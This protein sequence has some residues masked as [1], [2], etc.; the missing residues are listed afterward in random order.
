MDRVAKWLDINKLLLNVK[1]TKLLVVGNGQRLADF[2]DVVIKLHGKLVDRVDKI[3]YLGVKLDEK[4]SWTPHLHDLFK[5]LGHKLALFNRIAGSLNPEAMSM[6][7]KSYVLPIF[8]YGD[9]IW[10]DQRN[11]LLMDK[12]ECFQEG[13]L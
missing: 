9:S 10:G 2:E 5:R 1:K 13:F 11:T 4:F 3:T 8:D 7:Y 12:L 6:T